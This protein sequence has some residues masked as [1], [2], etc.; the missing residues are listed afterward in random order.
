MSH[1][2]AMQRSFACRSPGIAIMGTWA[3]SVRFFRISAKVRY[4]TTWVELYLSISV[5]NNY[6]LQPYGCV[7]RSVVRLFFVI[8]AI[9]ILREKNLGG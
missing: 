6:Y 2:A 1:P 4:R 9:F 3:V 7:D 8:G 5:C